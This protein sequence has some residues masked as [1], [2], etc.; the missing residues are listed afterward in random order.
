MENKKGP[1]DVNG[2]VTPISKKP[3]DQIDAVQWP[4]MNLGALWD[5]RT[6]LQTRLN[7]VLN[8]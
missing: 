4:D 7:I 1:I 2:D 3:V 8:N 5:Q 6:S